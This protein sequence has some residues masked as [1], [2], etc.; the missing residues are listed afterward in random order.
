[1][2]QWFESYRGVDNEL[3]KSLKTIDWRK[4]YDKISS[5]FVS[6]CHIPPFAPHKA[7][8]WERLVGMSKKLI[9]D[10]LNENFFRDISGEELCTFFCEV[11]DVLN[12][13]PLT[14]VSSDIDDF[15]YLSPMTLLNGSI[16][17][18]VPPGHF[19]RSEGVKHSWKTSQLLA[20]EFWNRWRKIYLPTLIPRKKWHIEF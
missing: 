8:C 7:G 4:V 16:L 10:I 9:L 3:Q 13:R 20:Q 5:H 1:M 12:N 11:Q 18:T 19:L 15:R 6:L 14:P 17:P 2:R